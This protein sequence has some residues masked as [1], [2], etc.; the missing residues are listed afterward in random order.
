MKRFK[1]ILLVC[2]EHSAQ[3][4]LIGRATALAKANHARVTV[5]NVIEVAPGELARLYGALPGARANDIAFELVEFHRTR[6]AQL[7]APIRT[8]G[9]ETSVAVLQ[10]IPFVEIIRKVVRDAHDLVIKAAAGEAEGKSLVFASTDL[11]LLRKCPCPVWVMKR[12]NR[13]HYARILAAVDPDP[14][15]VRK[16]ALNT[17]IMELATSLSSLEGSELHMSYVWKLEGE[18]TL[19]EWGLA[20]V[21]KAEVD[22]L[23]E[24]RRQRSEKLLH[25]LSSRFPLGQKE[26]QVHLLKGTAGEAIPRLAEQKQVD[27]IVMGTVGRTGIS[28]LIIG[29]TAEA[30]LNQVDCSVLAVKPPGFETPVRLNTKPTGVE[31]SL[32]S[33]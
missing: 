19:R 11:H 2:D 24:A 13:R 25:D 20:R 31:P 22:L 7:A 1:N 29:N 30:I 27:L 15:D 6:L 3:E 9:I 32:R 5:V 12:S 23:V 8:A 16:V 18:R 17:L 21:A 10:G 33:A 26:R 4:E 14:G 28:G